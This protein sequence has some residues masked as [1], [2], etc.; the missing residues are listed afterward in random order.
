MYEYDMLTFSMHVYFINIRLY[1]MT[2]AQIIIAAE[3][4]KSFG[5]AVLY[6]KKQSKQGKKL[7][8]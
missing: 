6:P 8:K 2:R 7:G 5:W 1:Y 3:L 4:W